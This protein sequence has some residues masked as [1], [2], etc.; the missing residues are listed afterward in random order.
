MTF[1]GAMNRLKIEA[2]QAVIVQR[3]LRLGEHSVRDL[4]ASKVERFGTHDTLVG[5]G[6]IGMRSKPI[7]C[8]P[9]AFALRS[10]STSTTAHK[11]EHHE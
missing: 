5:A 11:R 6:V 1:L 4:P 7:A 9:C 2:E 3:A 10:A 8:L